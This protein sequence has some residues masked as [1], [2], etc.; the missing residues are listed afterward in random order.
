MPDGGMDGGGI[1]APGQPAPSGGAA[2]SSMPGAGETGGGEEGM[3][4]D[5]SDS[6]SDGQSAGD[7]GDTGALP[8]G[9]G[10][11]GQDGEC[12]GGGAP[13]ASSDAAESGGGEAGSVDGG[14]SPGGGDASSAEAGGVSGTGGAGGVGEFPGESDAERAERLGQVL[15]ESLGDFDDVLLEEQQEIASVGRNTEG[16]GN[17]SG[18]SGGISLGEQA[19]DGSGSSVAVVNDAMAP[20]ESPTAGMSEEEV[21]ARTPEDVPMVA[22]D[23]IIARQLREAA[24]AEE[25]PELRE[26][27]WEEYRKYKG[28]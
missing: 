12:L 19:G 18:G 11:M 16:F 22:D 6:A 5:A 21:K 1:P 3:T 2:G 4:G 10:G 20:R 13:A 23:D 9:V 17:A 27:L 28:L 8:G 15:D 25:D 24:L 14:G 26:R 7:C